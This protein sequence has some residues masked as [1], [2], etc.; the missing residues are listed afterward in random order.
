MARGKQFSQMH[1]NSAPR[2]NKSNML[3]LN[4]EQVDGSEDDLDSGL[5]TETFVKRESLKEEK[6]LDSRKI[7]IP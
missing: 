4:V 7:R 5:G 1:R 2:K 3:L 6:K